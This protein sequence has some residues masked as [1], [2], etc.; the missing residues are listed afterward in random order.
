[1]PT[2][3]VAIAKPT[4]ALTL[5]GGGP[6]EIS[7]GLEYSYVRD[8]QTKQRECEMKSSFVQPQTAPTVTANSY[9]VVEASIVNA[10]EAN[11]VKFAVEEVGGSNG[12]TAKMSGRMVTRDAAGGIQNASDW[13]D[14]SGVTAVI[15]ASA[16][17]E[18]ASA[19]GDS[20]YDQY[21]AQVK[22]T[23][24]GSHGQVYVYGSASEV[25]QVASTSRSLTLTVAAEDTDVIAIAVQSTMASADHYL[26]EVLGE[27]MLPVLV[28]VAT[29]A[30][31][32]AGAAVSTTAKPAFV[33]SLS[34]A[35][36]A[37]VS[38]S[39]VG[40]ASGLTFNVR[41]TPIDVEGPVQMTQ[42]TFD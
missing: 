34:A 31:T 15:S 17:G 12:V 21:C 40:G 1:M 41:F 7:F 33:F 39:D 30:E 16:T 2:G 3:A 22:S 38:I 23:S 24:G 27:D 4:G 14:I 20:H 26:V 11:Y 19:V 8:S 13:A 5:N 32:G 28:G 36:A 10:S 37:T 6:L 42:V 9:A 18:L 35:G 25:L 29:V